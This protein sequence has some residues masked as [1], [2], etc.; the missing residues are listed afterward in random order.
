[1]ITP[2][3]VSYAV[4]AATII[5]A[6]F[7]HLEAPLLV[8]LFSYFALRQL[9]YV[10]RRKWLA[11]ALFI[12]G[13]TGVAAAGV[14]FTRTAVLA[15]PGV[16]DT[17]IPSASAW[18]QKS[19]ELPSLYE[20]DGY[21]VTCN[22]MGMMATVYDPEHKNDHNPLCWPYRATREDLQGLPP[23][24]I[25][26]NELDPLRDEGLK[27]YQMLLAAGVRVYSRTV[28]GACHAGDLI[29]RRAMPEVYVATIR[30]IKG[31]ADSL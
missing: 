25:S 18:A 20:N 27:Y 15:L 12:I 13:V 10:T 28:N 31:F 22:L 3:R 8:I 19:K 21:L 1:M 7:L 24:V 4:L 26:V 9:Y 14:Y 2:T 11:L 16:A 5:L 6:R 30:D 17:S 29:F 23:H